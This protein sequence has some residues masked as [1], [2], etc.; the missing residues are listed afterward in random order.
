VSLHFFRSSFALSSFVL[1]PYLVEFS[2]ANSTFIQLGSGCDSIHQTDC[3]ISL[4]TEKNGTLVLPP[5]QSAMI[6]TRNKVS[7][8]YGRVVIKA[9]MP[10]G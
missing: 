6:S 4:D 9:K 3:Q 2:F 1:T 5:I 8:K 10:K 7:I